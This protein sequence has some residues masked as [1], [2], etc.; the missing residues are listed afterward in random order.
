MGLYDCYFLIKNS[1][2]MK[3]D[4]INSIARCQ[5]GRISFRHKHFNRWFHVSENSFKKIFNLKSIP[6]NHLPV[7]KCQ[8]CI[9]N[10]VKD[11]GTIGDRANRIFLSWLPD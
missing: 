10:W 9:G 5:C 7:F 1:K 11:N 2:L 6:E 8:R 3:L 4:H